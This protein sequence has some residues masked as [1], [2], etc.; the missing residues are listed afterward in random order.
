MKSEA[1]RFDRLCE[2]FPPMKEHELD[3]LAAAAFLGQCVVV[4]RRFA[5][6]EL[7]PARGRAVQRLADTLAAY[8][9]EV[10]RLKQGEL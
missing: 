5:H 2:G 7:A 3:A 4:L 6:A 8:I 9:P 10:E 1:R